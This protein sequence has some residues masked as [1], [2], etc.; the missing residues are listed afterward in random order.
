MVKQKRDVLGEILKPSRGIGQGR[1][2]SSGSDLG[3]LAR[4]KLSFR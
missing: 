4:K 1:R 3:R 2:V